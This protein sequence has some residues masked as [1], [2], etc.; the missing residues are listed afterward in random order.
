MNTNC[1]NCPNFSLSKHAHA[2]A[3]VCVGVRCQTVRT[4]GTDRTNDPAFIISLRP[5]PSGNVPGV[6]GLRRLL[7]CLLRSYGLVAV[8]VQ[9]VRAASASEVACSQLAEELAEA[10]V[11]K[12]K[13][14]QKR[15]PESVPSILTEQKIDVRAAAAK[16]AGV[17]PDPEPTLNTNC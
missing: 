1:P 10:L 12:A 11:P 13:E 16:E 9:E 6:I 3:H 17:T 4:V 2:H 14:N 7:K 15:R 8:D 5:D